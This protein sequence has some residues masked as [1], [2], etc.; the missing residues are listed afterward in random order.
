MSAP[1]PLRA[2]WQRAE[3]RFLVSFLA[4][5]GGSFF[6]IAL[7]PVNDAVI[8]PYTA[9]VARMSGWVL[10]LLGEDAS[11]TGCI[12]A[13][14]RFA[15]TIYNGCNGL[16]TSLIFVSG[17]LAFPARWA[18]KLVGVLGGL[19][20][21]QLVN[22]VRIV[23]LF[24]TGVFLPRFFDDSHIFLWQSIVILFG[25]ALW[26]FWAHRLGARTPAAD[27]VPQ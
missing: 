3:V 7:H 22:L 13:S 18:A 16:V 20:A 6:V 19:I 4:L 2:A 10:T 11:V 24:Y 17:V 12:V 21:I 23:A 27:T 5:L 1:T 26:V 15:V 14:P 25:V 8:L 9:F